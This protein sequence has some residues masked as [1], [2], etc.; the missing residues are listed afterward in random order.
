M[1]WQN[2]T[3][4]HTSLSYD[5]LYSR[6]STSVILYLALAMLNI[7][8]HYTKYLQTFASNFVKEADSPETTKRESV[9]NAK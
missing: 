4:Q 5:A 3:K 7:W 2:G 1:D 8:V 9:G 6:I